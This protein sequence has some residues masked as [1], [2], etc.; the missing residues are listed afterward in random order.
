VP[1]REE[2]IAVGET[3]VQVVIGGQGDPLVV[4][5][6]AGGNRGW[7]RW[8]AA[9]AE[10]YTVYA[11]THPGFGRADAGAGVVG[12]DPQGPGKR[13]VQGLVGVE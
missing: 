9:V 13:R 4:L 11:P 1:P 8:M 10:R 12:E 6:G 2:M 3:K 5:H 7:R